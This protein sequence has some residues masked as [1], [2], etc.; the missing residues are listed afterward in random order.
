M[1][2]RDYFK[3]LK[4]YLF[5]SLLSAAGGALLALVAITTATR[6]G[7]Y[8]QHFFVSVPQ[9]FA[10]TVQNFR[11]EGYFAQEKARNFTDTAVAILTSVDFTSEFVPPDYSLSARKVAPQVVRIVAS[12]GDGSAAQ[13]LPAEAALHFNQKMIFLQA[14]PPARLIPISASP[15]LAASPPNKA[16]LSVFGAVVGS[17]FALAVVA[18][19]TYFKV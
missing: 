16:V 17:I 18:L 2:L 3:I 19:K 9:E 15:S 11:Y 1:E 7:T 5:F 14:T 10:P 12:S 4:K 8:Q 13:K 6:G